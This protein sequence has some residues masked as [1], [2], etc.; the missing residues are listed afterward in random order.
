MDQIFHAN[1][2]KLSKIV[3]NDW[4]RGKLPFFVPPTGCSFEPKPDNSDEANN[5]N[6]EEDDNE[7]EDKSEEESETEETVEPVQEDTEEKDNLFENVKFPEDKE[8]SEEAVPI[9]TPKPKI[10]LR[11]LV[12][13]EFKGIVQT[14]DYYDEDKYESGVKTKK[15]KNKY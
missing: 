10:D 6:A 15:N 13:Q 4:N 14:L 9:K 11:E 12:K 7:E 2:V 1:D 5:E 8:E 3:L